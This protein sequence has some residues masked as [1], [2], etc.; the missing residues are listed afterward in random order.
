[1]LADDLPEGV[2]PERLRY[3]EFTVS[4]LVDPEELQLKLNE[5][6]SY[7]LTQLFDTA[8]EVAYEESAHSHHQDGTG[9][10]CERGHVAK[11]ADNTF[12]HSSL[13]RRLGPDDPPR[14]EC[15]DCEAE[16]ERQQ[17]RIYGGG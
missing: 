9:Y 2:D 12:P 13:R 1:M 17:E 4:L 3:H 10:V 5:R 15:L 8:R 6:G 7:T 14:E 16:Y 11:R